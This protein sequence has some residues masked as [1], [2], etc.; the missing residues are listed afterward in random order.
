MLPKWEIQFASD[1]LTAERRKQ[2][3]KLSEREKKKGKNS[4][5]SKKYLIDEMF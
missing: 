2:G 1:K 3:N 4:F 5:T